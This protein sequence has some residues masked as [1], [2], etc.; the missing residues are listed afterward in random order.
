MTNYRTSNNSNTEV[1]NHK[2]NCLNRVYTYVQLYISLNIHTG[3]NKNHQ[4]CN[5][6]E[7]IQ[8]HSKIHSGR[9]AGTKN[10]RFSQIPS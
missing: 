1:L 5:I 8:I 9:Y 3:K 4:H 10:I 2:K 6:K 7:C